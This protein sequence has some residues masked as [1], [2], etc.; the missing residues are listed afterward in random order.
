M[1][2]DFFLNLASQM[3]EVWVYLLKDLKL[4]VRN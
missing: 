3:Q 4:V 1:D 2:I